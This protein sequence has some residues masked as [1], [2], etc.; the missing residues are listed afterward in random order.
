MMYK[1]EYNK[2]SEAFLDLELR[3][4]TEFIDENLSYASKEAVLKYIQENNFS[5]D[6][7]LEHINKEEI[8]KWAEEN[9]E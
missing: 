9:I 8:K 1:E 2:A 4:R 7:L 6:D 5:L 3:D